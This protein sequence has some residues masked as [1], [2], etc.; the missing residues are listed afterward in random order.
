MPETL[1]GVMSLTCLWADTPLAIDSSCNESVCDIGLQW[2]RRIE[3]TNF[4]VCL[5]LLYRL[6]LAI[7]LSVHTK[8]G[9]IAGRRLR[10]E[11][12]GPLSADTED[13]P[14]LTYSSSSKSKAYS[15]A[16]PVRDCIAWREAVVFVRH[17]RIPFTSCF[18]FFIGV[19]KDVISSSLWL[20]TKDIH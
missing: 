5:P 6:L 7:R 15:L 8:I 3:C 9:N 19:E 10:T 17:Y 14:L 2:V 4:T 1:D 16:W 20:R 11:R 12:W 13:S 18:T